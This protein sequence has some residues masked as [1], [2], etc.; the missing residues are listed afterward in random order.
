MLSGLFS[1][2]KISLKK[3]DIRSNGNSR[4]VF[5]GFLKILTSELL[6]FSQGL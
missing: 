4:Q 2:S 6:L 1:I 5:W 3:A